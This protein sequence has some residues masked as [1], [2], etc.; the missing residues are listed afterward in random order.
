M[1]RG[2]RPTIADVARLAAVDPSVVSKVLNADPS[3]QVRDQ[4]RE[5]VRNAVAEL[6]YV[7]NYTARRLRSGSGAIGLLVPEY[8]TPGNADIIAGA[9]EA[10][11]ARG[12]L[13]W[14]ASTEGYPQ[15]RYLDLFRSGIVDALLV[16]GARTADELAAIALSGPPVLLVNN[17]TTGADRWLVG[18]DDRAAAIATERLLQAGHRRIG[19]IS[20]RPDL[21]WTERRRVGFLQAMDRAGIPADPRWQAY[22]DLTPEGGAAAIGQ[23]LAWSERPTALV[24][25]HGHAC[26]GAWAELRSRGLRVPED[27][28]LITISRLPFERTRSPAV[29]RV[30]MPLRAIGRRA[31][32][33]VLDTPP[34]APIH[35][36]LV[37]PVTFIDGDT[38]GPPPP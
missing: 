5:R 31:V 35:E 20:G 14:T 1:R 22:G 7:P 28:S 19:F 30:E 10:A 37:G 4:T 8:W 23:I 2:R 27:L 25:F 9:E 38:V 16:A 12:T 36:V 6:G 15:A 32:E 18:E 11:T 3:L 17:R 21:H 29:T 33:L 24:V 34:T 13:L 26:L